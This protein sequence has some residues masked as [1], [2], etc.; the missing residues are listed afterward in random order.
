VRTGDQWK[1]SK[2][3]L[4]P[5]IRVDTAIRLLESDKALI[6]RAEAARREKDISA[7]KA[8]RDINL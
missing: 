2:P 7:L 1:I 8:I 4:A 5:H 3:H 6:P